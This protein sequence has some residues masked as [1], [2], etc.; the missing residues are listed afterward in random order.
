MITIKIL[1]PNYL[2]NIEGL[3]FVV[4]CFLHNPW[5][6]GNN[7]R[8]KIL[9]FLWL[10]IKGKKE[11]F[12]LPSVKSGKN[13]LRGAMFL[14]LINVTLTLNLV[15]TPHITK[16]Q[17]ERLTNHLGSSIWTQTISFHCNLKYSNSLH[18]T[19]LYTETNLASFKYKQNTPKKSLSNPN[20]LLF[21]IVQ[22]QTK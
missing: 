5:K 22:V 21:D 3:D 1:S 4:R 12:Y 6:R 2:L 7:V 14:Q 8:C 13:K 9:F 20:S 15:R 17:K 10:A 11:S 16:E 18:T 19:I